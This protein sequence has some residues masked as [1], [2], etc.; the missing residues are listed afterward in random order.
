MFNSI[1][2]YPIR[3]DLFAQ[4]IHPSSP[5]LA[6]GLASGH[7]QI[8][9]LPSSD[10]NEARNSTIETA[11]RTR[12]HKGSCRSLCFDH[13]GQQLFSAGTDGIVKVAATETGQVASKIAVPLHTDSID[14][15]C[16]LHAQTPQT[17][18][19]STDSSALYLYDLRANSTF[20]SS[21]PQQTH[22]PHDDYVSSITPLPPT[23]NS[24]SGLSKQW[25]TTGGSTIAIMDIRKGVLI[26]SEDQGEE[27]LSSCT[28][29]GKLVVGSEKGVLR[30]WQVG[31]WDDNEQTVAL[32][33]KGASAD[34][35]A[36]VGESPMLAVG[37]DDGCVRFVDMGRKRPKVL[38]E[39]EV[40]HDEV[41][42]VL[43]LGFEVGRRMISGGGRVVK[44]WEDSHG[45]DDGE[46]EEEEDEESG[47]TNGKRVNDFGSDE[48]GSVEG[49]NESS[50]EEQRKRKKKKKRKRNKGKDQ[51][52][53]QQHVIGFK[54]MD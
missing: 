9:R 20:A 45:V 50:E 13:D 54:G 36:A 14:P 2:T 11:W 4:A 30:I 26:Q 31:S 34:V 16:V 7:V 1:C 46:D 35:L 43:G 52:G 39:T 28:V 32:V 22:H 3:S 47:A 38:H 8:Q 37:M 33:G 12:R 49:R 29:D 6:L 17:L 41:E 18:L 51:S 15:T 53:G 42:G 19:L 27:I 21:K 10:V 23:E 48:D 44:V 24:T 40:R 5:L 25:A